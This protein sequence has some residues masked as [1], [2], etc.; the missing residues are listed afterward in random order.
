MRASG[1][2]RQSS[3]DSFYAIAGH[4]EYE[5]TGV[6]LALG[7]ERMLP[8]A[9]SKEKRPSTKPQRCGPINAVED[10]FAG[11]HLLRSQSGTSRHFAAHT[12]A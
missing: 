3:L 9:R 1:I 12:K 4:A 5:D 8:A 6:A 10:E 11:K 2:K 7:A